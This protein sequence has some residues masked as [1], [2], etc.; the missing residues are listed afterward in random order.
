MTTKSGKTSIPEG[1]QDLLHSAAVAHVAAIGKRGEPHVDPAWFGP[2]EHLKF[3]QTKALQKYENVG[4]NPRISVPV[5]DP[6][7][8]LRYLETR[9]EVVRVKEGPDLDLIN[10]VSRKYLGLHKY[11]YHRPGDER[12]GLYVETHRTIQMG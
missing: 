9:G 2:G 5:V 6:E 7:G 11:P 1:Y 4:R 10:E 3:S 12:I 8:H